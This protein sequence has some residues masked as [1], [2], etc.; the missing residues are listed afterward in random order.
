MAE[1]VLVDWL[2][3][4][5]ALSQAHVLCPKRLHPFRKVGHD[6]IQRHRLG[7]KNL[8]FPRHL[9]LVTL[10]FPHL[11]HVECSQQTVPL[12]TFNHYFVH[13]IQ[14]LLQDVDLNLEVLH[15]LTLAT[16][17]VTIHWKAL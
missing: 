17:F 6:L 11:L 9:Q 10:G 12:L 2:D 14:F 7:L 1:R 4:I 5:G 3:C 8:L 13:S 16:T 15:Q